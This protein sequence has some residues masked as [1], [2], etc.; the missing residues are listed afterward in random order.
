MLYFDLSSA[1]SANNVM[2]VACRQFVPQTTVASPRG[3]RP[4]VFGEKLQRPVDRGLRQA[5]E[6]L[7]GFPINIAR[8]EVF[9]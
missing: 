4:P 2:M 3:T 6:I 1:N 9:A 7:F 5:R 8:R